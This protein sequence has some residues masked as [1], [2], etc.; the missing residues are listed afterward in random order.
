[1]TMRKTALK[2]RAGRAQ[3]AACFVPF[4]ESLTTPVLE[5]RPVGRKRGDWR[6]VRGPHDWPSYLVRGRVV[7]AWIWGAKNVALVRRLIWG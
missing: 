3:N 6:I 7:V 1:M 5:V 2:Q 4:L